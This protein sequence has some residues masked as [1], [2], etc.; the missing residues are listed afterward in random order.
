MKYMIGA[1]AA[2]SIACAA[3]L[4]ATQKPK[5]AVDILSQAIPESTTPAEAHKE[6]SALRFK[7]AATEAMSAQVDASRLKHNI[8]SALLVLNFIVLLLVLISRNSESNQSLKQTPDG[9][10]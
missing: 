4:V 5:P 7:L 6:I 10:A 2:M 8:V 3:W 9:A 1:M